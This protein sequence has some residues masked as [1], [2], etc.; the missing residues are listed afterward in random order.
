MAG[1]LSNSSANK[2]LIRAAMDT[3]SLLHFVDSRKWG[4]P[5]SLDMW[6]NI[7][8]EASPTSGFHVSHASQGGDQVAWGRHSKNKQRSIKMTSPP[9]TLSLENVVL[10]DRITSLDKQ[11]SVGRWH[12]ADFSDSNMRDWVGKRW[13]T[14]LG[15]M[16]TVVGLLK[17]WYSFH[18]LSQEDLEKI[19][20]L[21]WINGKSFLAL[22]H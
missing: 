6:C 16:L 22:H 15:Y 14:M 7:L 18:F 1:H 4:G 9:P 12:F 21:P 20:S 13:K 8:G 10:I 3:E 2:A 5:R 17:G 19:K 11:A